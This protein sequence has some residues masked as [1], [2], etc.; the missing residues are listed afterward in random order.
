MVIQKFP[1]IYAKTVHVVP[2]GGSCDRQAGGNTML[3]RGS[4]LN[5]VFG[6]RQYFIGSQMDITAMHLAGG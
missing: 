3:R 5:N 6:D 1:N 4:R 2:E